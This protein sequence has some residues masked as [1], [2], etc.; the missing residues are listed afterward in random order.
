MYLPIATGFHY[1]LEDI[2]I[3]DEVKGYR[4][5]VTSKQI[6]VIWQGFK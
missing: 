4:L 5:K 1:I 2:T 3:L 6:P